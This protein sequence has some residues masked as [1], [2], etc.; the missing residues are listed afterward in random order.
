MAAAGLTPGILRMLQGLARRELS[1][2][3]LLFV[4]GHRPLAWLG[5]QALHLAT[6]WA[7]LLGLPGWADWA[8]LLERP[9]G[10]LLIEDY[11]RRSA[12]SPPADRA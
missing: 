8:T 2:A 6:P 5:A 11:L 3:V 9:D 1:T 12:A 10:L 7:D 4:A